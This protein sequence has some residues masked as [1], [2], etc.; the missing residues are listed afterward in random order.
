[1]PP[2]VARRS[3]TTI[4]RAVRMQNSAAAPAKTRSRPALGSQPSNPVRAQPSRMSATVSPPTCL[5]GLFNVRGAE[6]SGK[7]GCGVGLDKQAA[8]L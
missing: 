4:S 3:G 1:M 5:S 6:L 7:A 2:A 8:G